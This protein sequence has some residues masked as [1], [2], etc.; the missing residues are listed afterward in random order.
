MTE[1]SFFRI[2]LI[3]SFII[4]GGTFIALFFVSAPYGR[5][6]R[7]G[8]GPHLPSWLGWLLMESVSAIGMLVMFVIGDAPKTATLIFFLLLWEAHYIHRAFVYPFSLRD[9]RKKMPLVVTL[10]AVGFNLGNAYING[11]Y[12]FHFSNG[13]YMTG[14]LLEPRFLLGMVLFVIGFG[15][16]RWADNILHS[17]RQPGE[18]DYKIPHGGLYRF[19]SCPNYFGEIIEWFGWALATWSLPGLAFAVW[20]FANLAPR[21]WS[22]HKWYHEQFSDYPPKRK[23]LIPGVW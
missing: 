18:T 7:Q 15:I 9:G 13:R 22:H 14:W 19:I 23:A 17:L 1:A 8:W 20:T 2:I 4:A 5:H 16:N 11:R 21:A 12:L 10:L 3:G 6:I